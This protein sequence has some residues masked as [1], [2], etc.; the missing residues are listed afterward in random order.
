[1]E[2]VHEDRNARAET[3]W[4]LISLQTLN[5]VVKYTFYFIFCHILLVSYHEQYFEQ[6]CQNQCQFRETFCHVGFKKTSTFKF[7]FRHVIFLPT[8]P[9]SFLFYFTRLLILMLSNSKSIKSLWETNVTISIL[10][11]TMQL[12]SVYIRFPC[13]DIDCKIYDGSQICIYHLCCLSSTRRLGIDISCMP[14]SKTGTGSQKIAMTD[15]V[16]WW[17]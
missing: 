7:P 6:L 16:A 17:D 5:F 9:L 11:S 13:Q 12:I 2:C 10:F 8:S 14:R 1:M 15:D 4:K 3:S